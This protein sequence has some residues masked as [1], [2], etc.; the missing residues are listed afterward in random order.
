MQWSGITKL[1]E[2]VP[3]GLNKIHCKKGMTI[4]EGCRQIGVTEA[5]LLQ[6]ANKYG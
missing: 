4:A 2:V 5:N 6:V 3:Q 1:R